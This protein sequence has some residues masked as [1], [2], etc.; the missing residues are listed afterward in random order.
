MPHFDASGDGKAFNGLLTLKSILFTLA[1][2][3][4]YLKASCDSDFKTVDL[5]FISCWI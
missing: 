3:S 4:S 5:V 1:S 2:L